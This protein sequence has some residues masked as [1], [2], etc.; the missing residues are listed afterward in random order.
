[1]FILKIDGY[2]LNAEINYQLK[3]Y[4]FCDLN[5]YDMLVKTKSNL[6]SKSCRF[7]IKAISMEDDK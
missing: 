3:K 6:D 5:F 4:C 7:L 1:M 2:N